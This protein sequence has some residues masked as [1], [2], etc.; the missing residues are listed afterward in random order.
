L[1]VDLQADDDFVR[2]GS[3]H[4]GILVSEEFLDRDFKI[5]DDRI[6]P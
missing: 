5:G 1:N 6:S 2:E 4:D 3:S